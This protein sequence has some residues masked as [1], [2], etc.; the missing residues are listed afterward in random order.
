MLQSHN[1][2]DAWFELYLKTILKTILDGSNSFPAVYKT[3]VPVMN[4]MR[5]RNYT[6]EIF[7]LLYCNI[8]FLNIQNQSLGGRRGRD[9]MVVGFTTT[10]AIGACH[11]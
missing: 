11:H 8:I 4:S 6:R 9:R 5:N 3:E 1:S 2:L 7:V 10:Y